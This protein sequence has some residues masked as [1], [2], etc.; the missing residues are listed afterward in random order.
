M[1][2]EKSYLDCFKGTGLLKRRLPERIAVF[3]ILI[4][5]VIVF[6]PIFWTWFM[7]KEIFIFFKEKWEEIG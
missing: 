5:S 4:F 6:A 1:R 7:L 3:T 2:D